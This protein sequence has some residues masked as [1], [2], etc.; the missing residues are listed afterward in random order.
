MD[1]S[2]SLDS[3]TSEKYFRVAS[4][5]IAFYD[6]LI[7]LPAEWR[8]YRSQSSIFH[9]S[10]SCVLFILIRY[11]SVLVMALSNYGYFATGFTQQTCQYYY[12]ATPAFKVI[13]SMISQIILGVRTFNI[14]RRDK[15]LGIL[16]LLLYFITISVEWFTNLYHRIPVVAQGNCTPVNS[17][18][19]LSAWIYYLAAMLY[20]LIMLTISTIHLLRYDPL[21]NR[22][23]NSLPSLEWVDW[24]VCSACNNHP[25][26]MSLATNLLNLILYHTSNAETQASGASMGY[27]VTWIMSQRI[28]INIREMTEPDP[29]YLENVVIARPATFSSARKNAMSGLR[30]QFELKSHSKN[31]KS[32]ISPEFPPTSSR[33]GHPDGVELDGAVFVTFPTWGCVEDTKDYRLSRTTAIA[34]RLVGSCLVCTTE[35]RGSKGQ[36][37]REFNMSA[38]MASQWKLRPEA[39]RAQKIRNSA[40]AFTAPM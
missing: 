32:P 28:L 18:K 15:T 14:A 26:K 19:L 40:H 25:P 2:V 1:R 4:I 20:D 31:S 33:S 16:L 21:S 27:A 17:G 3:A 6:Y 22:F 24:Q 11:I 34:T 7:T 12:L 38:Y 39:P 37:G 5:S 9:L 29:R 8:F 23:A 35:W 13:Q 10:L 36:T 30:S